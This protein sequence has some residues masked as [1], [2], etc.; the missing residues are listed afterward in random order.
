MCLKSLGH[1][2]DFMLKTKRLEDQLTA[3]NHEKDLLEGDL[4]RMPG[5]GRTLSERNHRIAVE[6]RLEFL[7]REIGTIR[8]QLKRVGALKR[9]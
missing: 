9:T 3:D 1:V 7:R 6:T 5:S 4:A 8:M 2:Q